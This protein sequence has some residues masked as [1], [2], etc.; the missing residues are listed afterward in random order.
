[1][2]ENEIKFALKDYDKLEKLLTTKYGW[3]DIRQGYLNPNN[4]IREITHQSGLIEYVFS[5]KQRVPS[6]RMIEIESDQ[7]TKDN[8]EHLWEFTKERLFKRRTS[9]FLSPELRW[10]VDFPRWPN[11]GKYFAMA[12]I[13][14]PEEMEEPPF[15]LKELKPFIAFQVPR[16]DHRWSARKISSEKHA[17]ELAKELGRKLK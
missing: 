5:F 15:I 6:G 3:H 12:E 9:V 8:F 11:N 4:R 2:I 7:I 1:M 13:E 14:M 16:D 10:D 17:K